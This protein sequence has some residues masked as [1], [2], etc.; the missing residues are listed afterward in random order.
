[1]R[2]LALALLMLPLL[3]GKRA[4][5][6]PPTMLEDGPVVSL[7]PLYPVTAGDRRLAALVYDPI[8]FPNPSGGGWTSLVLE[9]WSAEPD[10]RLRLTVRK[11]LKWHDG[12]EAEAA[13]LCATVSA[14]TAERTTAVIARLARLAPATCSVDSEDLRVAWVTPTVREA[15][16]WR[17]LAVPLLPSHRVGG[18]VAFTDL[19][20]PMGTGPYRARFDGHL[21]RFEDAG[22]VHRRAPVPV[23][24]RAWAPLAAARL[25]ALRAGGAQA[26][27]ELAPPDLLELRGEEAYTLRFVD[28]RRWT[29]LLLDTSDGPLA[30]PAIRL[31]VD[32]ALDRSAL[33]DEVTGVD[34]EREVQ[35]VTVLTGPGPHE[36][37]RYNR[38][39]PL[40]KPDLEAAKA[41][42]G[43]G[44]TL[45]LGVD[46]GADA[47]P[48]LA[49]ALTHR[50][51]V[52]GFTVER[53]ELTPEAWFDEVLSG[54]RADA[55]DVVLVTFDSDHDMDH[56]L[57]TRRD[58][59]G[60]LQPFTAGHPELDRALDDV[61]RSSDRNAALRELHALLADNRALI[62]L[63]QT[64][65]WTAWRSEWFE[66]Q[67]ISARDYFGAIERWTPK[68]QKAK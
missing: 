49:D 14:L 51:G 29:G 2:R 10:G 47:G 31:A 56:W 59:R 50:L 22:A 9:T 68:D 48:R 12:E 46:P 34:L 62:P 20:T 39:V 5:V 55:L 41:A 45:R 25:G 53:V 23:L 7:N 54:A 60:A 13:D 35:P 28:R 4:S 21:W 33:R 36:S 65:A 67:P 58:D 30:D 63:W 16:P 52:A 43:D 17:H 40:P 32:Q 1:M 37:P 19:Q 3:A 24:E 66:H 44:I 8:F 11:G 61:R 6:P 18:A 27:I 15:E 64:D 57:H 26:I 42:V 38:G